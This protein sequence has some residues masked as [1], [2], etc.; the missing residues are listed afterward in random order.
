MTWEIFTV[1]SETSRQA[2][3]EFV[4]AG[5]GLALF[6]AGCF[7]SLTAAA[8]S[9]VAETLFS[10]VLYRSHLQRMTETRFKDFIP[11]YC[12]SALLTFAATAP[13]ATLIVYWRNAPDLPPLQLLGAVATGVSLWILGL[14]IMGHPLIVEA[15][16][17]IARLR[18][19]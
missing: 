4:R 6:T 1:R 7:I 10:M 13:S 9:R 5:V 2:K 17:V 14:V 11:I 19:A 3:I 18:Q 16:R 15:K 8:A 12:R